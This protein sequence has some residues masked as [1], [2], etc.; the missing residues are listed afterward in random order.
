MARSALSFRPTSSG[1]RPVRACR[2][3]SPLRTDV[4]ASIG[5]VSENAMNRTVVTLMITSLF[6]A[7]ASLTSA[8]QAFKTPD[9]AAGALAAAARAGDM[10]ALVT[11]LGPDGR[12]I[13]SS[14][15]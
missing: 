7:V 6:C 2:S 13:V 12:D 4:S 14:G 11:V 9:E 1:S 5:R 10:K 3:V 15:D 8:Q